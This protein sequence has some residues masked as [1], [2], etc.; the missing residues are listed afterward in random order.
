MTAADGAEKAGPAPFPWEAAMEAGLSRLRLP[1]P[2]F[3]RMTPRELASA[4]GLSA[5]S[6]A[7]PDRAGLARMMREFPDDAV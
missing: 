5:Q 7:A 1:A 4:L 6:G 2:D 3:W